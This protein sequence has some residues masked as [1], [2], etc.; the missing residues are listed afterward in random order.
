M[1]QHRD[2]SRHL[3][4]SM[5][6]MNKS[7]K[8]IALLSLLV[9]GCS[10]MMSTT[11]AAN[12][13]I[14]LA[15]E[16]NKGMIRRMLQ[17][18]TTS[19]STS[20]N[21]TS[22]N[23]TSS[24]ST[25]SNSTSSNSTSGSNSTSTN[26]SSSSNSTTVPTTN[27]TGNS[28]QDN[29]TDSGNQVVEEPNPFPDF[30]QLVSDVSSLDI[31]TFYK[32]VIKQMKISDKLQEIQVKLQNK[33]KISKEGMSTMKNFLKSF[34]MSFKEIYNKTLFVN[35]NLNN[36]RAVR[37]VYLRADL[38]QY[39]SMVVYDATL[40]LEQ[41]NKKSSDDDED[42]DTKFL[43]IGL[44]ILLGTM[45]LLTPLIVFCFCLKK[46]RDEDGKEKY[47][48]RKRCLKCTWIVR[49]CRKNYR[50][51]TVTSGGDYSK[52]TQRSVIQT[53]ISMTPNVSYVDNSIYNHSP[54]LQ[55]DNNSHTKVKGTESN[56]PI[57]HITLH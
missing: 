16:I 39:E 43:K 37:D 40:A 29:D 53:D 14:D 13:K 41:A 11:S 48:C 17:T 22:S 26:S 1:Q 38:T 42:S 23:S 45:L 57:D 18:T 4:N 2:T 20:S 25:S 9:L 28:T 49:I 34:D 35:V 15:Q 19:N 56:I 46:K 51:K 36:D 5:L 47:I 10:L 33:S 7:T 21:S 50:V 6:S 3:N 24:N 55:T 32:S 8:T 27:G 30:S 31:Y 52:A 12:V 44:P 54:M